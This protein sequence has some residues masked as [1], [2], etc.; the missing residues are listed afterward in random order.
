M[1]DKKCRLGKYNL[2][3]TGYNECYFALILLLEILK[4]DFYH[5]LFISYLL[6]GREKVNLGRARFPEKRNAQYGFSRVLD[7][8]F[9]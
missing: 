2:I 3:A 1:S 7:I 5:F 9:Q 6:F 4:M 8:T